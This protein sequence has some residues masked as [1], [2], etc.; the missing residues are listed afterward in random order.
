MCVFVS[1]QPFIIVS[2][3]S[4]NTG[5]L[6]VSSCKSVILLAEN[7]WSSAIADQLKNPEF[8]W[9]KFGDHLEPKTN[10]RLA[11]FQL[12]QYRQGTMESIDDFVARCKVQAAKCAFRDQQ[13][14]E[15]RVFEQIIA[16]ICHTEIQKDYCQKKKCTLEE[17]MNVCRNF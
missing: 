12:Q 8:I 7:S 13:E 14:S 3:S 1:G 16:G 11:R 2:R 15:D 9:K 5:D 17:A 10:F 4:H 6:R